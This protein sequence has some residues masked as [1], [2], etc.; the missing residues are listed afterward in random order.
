MSFKKSWQQQLSWRQIKTNCAVPNVF[1]TKPRP[2]ASSAAPKSKALTFCCQSENL[3]LNILDH[4][5]TCTAYKPSSL[6]VSP[7]KG[8]KIANTTQKYRKMVARDM[9]IYG[10]MF[11]KR[12]HVST[13]PTQIFLSNHQTSSN[14]PGNSRGILP[15]TPPA[16]STLPKP[17]GRKSAS[18]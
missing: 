7:N 9:L 3:D 4:A 13:K 10:M 2:N 1:E 11:R 15:K 6:H 18:H 14:L 8:I 12:S 17:G 16:N 5:C